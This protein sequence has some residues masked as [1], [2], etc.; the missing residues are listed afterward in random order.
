MLLD[1]LTNDM[2][3]A[4]RSRDTLKLSVLRMVLSD[5][6]YV[7]VEKLRELEEAD[8]VAVIKKGIKSREDSVQQF[9]AAG[10]D[11]LADKEA[12]EAA[13]LK[14]Y[15]PEQVSGAE[16]EA[17]VVAAIAESGA[18]SVKEMGKVMKIVL[19]AH[20]A[21]VDGKEVQRLVAAKL[22]G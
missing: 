7:K 12:A 1:Q 16:L 22:A 2:K 9:R 19:A 10:R 3:D 18:T 14:V 6:K 4:M 13:L 21:R 17:I 5:C 15:L 20:G 8:V 11:D